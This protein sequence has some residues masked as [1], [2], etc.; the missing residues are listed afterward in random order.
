MASINNGQHQWYTVSCG[1]SI[2]TLP[3]RYQNI[4]LIGQGTYGIVVRAT[5]TATGK[6]VAI[7][8]LLHPFQTHIHAKRTYRELKLLMYL[9]HPDAQVVQLYNVFTPEQN[10]ND[11]QTL[12]FVL[13]FV[14]RDLNRIILQ[15]MPLTEDLIRLTIYSILRGLKFIHSADILHRDLKPT[16]IGVDRNSNVTILDFGLARV[17]SNGAHT[18]YV[19][20]RWWRAPEIYLNEKK[21][22]EKVDVW[23]VGCIMAELI[24][25]KPLFPGKDTIDQLNKIFDIIGTPD[26]TTIQKI[27]TAEA[28]AYISQMDPKPKRDFNELFGFKYDPLTGTIISGISP[29]GIDLLDR[30][31]SFDPDQRPTAEKAL[32]HPF[33]GFYH[34]PIDE[35]TIGPMIDEHQNAEYSKEQ[36]KSIVWQMVEEFLPPSWVNQDLINDS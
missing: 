24:L 20:T 22:N 25:L 23:S 36:W 26:P 3:V 12:Y 28:F 4:A 2:F 35:P 10:V 19:S 17:A 21:Y 16:N 29:E 7:K 14:D 11:F 15:R 13:N 32:G 6:Y 18:E 34:D 1:N 33:L 30:L 9:N 8:K 31:L 27:C 5:D